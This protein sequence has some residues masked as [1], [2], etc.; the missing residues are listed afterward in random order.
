MTPAN[1]YDEVPYPTEPQRR[2]HPDRLATAAV[3][4][5]LEP[6]PLERCRVLDLGCG[7]GANLVAM[8][9]ALPDGE[10]IGVDLTAAHVAHG[11]YLA[12]T[13]GLKNVSFL[14]RDLLDGV[15]DL[16]RFDYIVAHG[17]YSWTPPAVRDRVLAI[18]GECLT[19][20]GVAFVS[21][22][23]YP[24]AYHRRMARE[25][26]LYHAPKATPCAPNS[27]RPATC[28]PSCGRHAAPERYREIIREEKDIL[29]RYGDENYVHD[30]LGPINHPVYFHEFMAHAARHRLQYLSDSAVSHTPR[31]QYPPAVIDKLNGLGEGRHAWSS[32]RDFLDGRLFRETLLCRQELS[33]AS[34]ARPENVQGLFVMSPA[35][36]VPARRRRPRSRS[37]CPS[38]ETIQTEQPLAQAALAVLGER[39]PG[40]LSFPELLSEALAR[41][42]SQSGEG[43]GAI[44][45]AEF[46]LVA[47][48]LRVVN[49][50]AHAPR[51]TASA[52]ERPVASPL[53]RWQLRRSRPLT[54]VWHAPLKMDDP[55]IRYLFMLLD[56]THDRAALTEELA[57]FIQQRAARPPRAAAIHWISE[58]KS[59]LRSLLAKPHGRQSRTASRGC[60][61]LW[62]RGCGVF[63][64]R[65]GLTR[66]RR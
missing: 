41:S 53:A 22:S 10:F 20:R 33:L 32:T 13:C 50:S 15:A 14:Q 56:G 64:Y 49:F 47:E 1:P 58:P 54:N 44:D 51:F 36:P 5:G 2:T 35:K 65:K 28:R 25:M 61:C 16:G 52:S 66:Q 4:M 26:L 11:R 57:A 27:I 43:S 30:I 34:E 38:G 31:G 18:C 21:Y 45:L 48:G 46:L 23:V 39:W 42:G 6:P 37:S 8:A 9:L 12:E 59:T 29:D 24:G 55:V 62:R 19:E 60:A 17:V 40:A 7:G 3:L 63:R